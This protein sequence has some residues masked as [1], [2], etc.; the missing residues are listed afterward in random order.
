MFPKCIHV[1]Q[2]IHRWLIE[3]HQ[4]RMGKNHC[5]HELQWS[6]DLVQ[7]NSSILGNSKQIGNDCGL[8][9]MI[10]Q[11]LL[12]DRLFLQA[13]G[14]TGKEK[15]LFSIEMRRRVILSVHFG[16]LFFEPY[17]QKSWS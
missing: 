12:Q 6:H 5:L 7:D 2:C 3:Y 4:L 8:H 1:S 15:A 10:L 13:F 16:K 14:N 11:I 17:V 9:T